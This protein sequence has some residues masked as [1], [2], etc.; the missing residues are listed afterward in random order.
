MTGKTVT[1]GIRGSPLSDSRLSNSLLYG[2]LDKS[3]MQMNATKLASLRNMRQMY[4]REK[5]L[6]SEFLC[7]LGVLF[8]Q[9][10]DQKDTGIVFLDITF[11][12]FFQKLKPLFNFGNNSFWQ[13]DSPVFFRH[14]GPVSFG[15]FFSNHA[16]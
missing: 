8:S 15:S 2:F 1:K 5:P 12:Q 4:C 11:V 6:P 13:R 14:S 9:G 16:Y 10:I 3:L 7:R